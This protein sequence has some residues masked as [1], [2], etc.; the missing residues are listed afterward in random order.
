VKC[1]CLIAC[2]QNSF[3]IE[4]D[5]RYELIS[6]EKSRWRKFKPSVRDVLEVKYLN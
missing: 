1:V 6:E 4:A 3:R 2:S 5:S